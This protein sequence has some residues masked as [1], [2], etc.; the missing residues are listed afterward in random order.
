MAVM[1][2]SIEPCAVCTMIGG[3][4]ACR[5]ALEHLHAVDAGHDEVEQDEG[6]GR[7]VG[8]LEDLQGL[9]AALGGAGS[10]NRDA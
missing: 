10:R 3:V 6:D 5:Q 7:A 8:T 4:P 1:A 2:A 9:L